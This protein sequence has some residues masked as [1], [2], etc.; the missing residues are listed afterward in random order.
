MLR[1]QVQVVKVN[2]MA[3]GTVRL[4]IDLLS[5]DG[6]DMK[7]AYE[8]INEG[9]VTMILTPTETLPQAIID[10]GRSLSDEESH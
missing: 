3:D 6:D 4:T 5:G 2:T 10:V 9:E 1:K 8:M 7:T